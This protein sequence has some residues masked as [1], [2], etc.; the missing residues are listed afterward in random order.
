M[1]EPT[2]PPSSDRT[3]APLLNRRDVLTGTLAAGGLL[4]VAGSHAQTPAEL[5]GSSRELWQW[6]RTQP[7]IDSQLTYLDA[8]GSGPTWRAAMAVEY[9]AREQ[10]SMELP[11][12]VLNN[13]WPAETQRLAERFAA[14]CGCSADEIL[15]T[16]GAGEALGQVAAGLELSAGDEVIIGTQ[17]H[18]A[19]LSPWLFLARRRGIVVKQVRIPS[20]L[21]N[22]QE[23]LDLFSAA[24]TSRARVLAFSHVQYGDGTVMPV[25][26][27][28]DLAR[29]RNLISVVDGAQALGMLNL[30]LRELRCDFYATSCHKWLGGCHGTGLLFM[31]REMLDRLWPVQPRGIDATPPVYTPTDSVGNNDVP[32]ALHKFGNLVPQ[33]W[34]ALRGCVSALDF[35]DQIGRARIEARIRELAVYTRLRL[36]PLSALKLLTPSRPGL[37]AGILTFRVPG[38]RAE[39]MAMLL[40]RNN[41]IHVRAL[42]WPQSDEGA[43]RVALH[44]FNSPDDA[45]RLAQAMRQFAGP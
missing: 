32:A 23:V 4:Q 21:A 44:I 28:C 1:S 11:G 30:Q 26:E 41:R 9:R 15:F 20:P 36:Q 14:F 43:L 8:A 40:G 37:W 5:P 7:V 2:A 25:R 22:P 17:E 24:I 18:P 42:R 35:H 33:L 34:P 12:S 39:E 13:R 6:V 29:Q 45:D 19:A 38:R 3:D 31:R 16:H 27:L 10:Q